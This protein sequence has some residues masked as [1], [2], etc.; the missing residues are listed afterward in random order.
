MTA[1][2]AGIYNSRFMKTLGNEQIDAYLKNGLFK[3]SYYKRNAVL[4]LQ[5]EVCEKLELILWG[6]VAVERIDESGGL[7][8]VTEFLRDDLIGGNL[9]FSKKALY[10]MTI[11][12]KQDSAILEISKDTMFKLLSSYPDFLRVYLEYASDNANILAVK[13][14]HYIKRPLRE[15]IITFLNHERIK[16]RSNHIVLNMTKKALAEKIGVQRTSLSRELLKM[17]RDGLVLYDEVSITLLK[18]G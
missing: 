14:S 1:E 6:S 17:K 10:P 9:I 12:V 15:S 4:H 2:R 13:I 5:S 8:N 11:T 3:V 7:L 18:I 16:Q